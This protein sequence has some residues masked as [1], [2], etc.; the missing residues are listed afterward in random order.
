MS[1]IVSS[2]SKRNEETA[3]ERSGRDPPS[4]YSSNLT[5][6]KKSL[7]ILSKGTNRAKDWR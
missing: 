2:P 7:N 5:N 1:H 4:T 3:L 6:A